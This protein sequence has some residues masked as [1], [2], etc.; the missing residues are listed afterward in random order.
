MTCV[1]ASADI[2]HVLGK[3]GRLSTVCYLVCFVLVP[4]L[5]ISRKIIVVS[6]FVLMGQLPRLLNTYGGVRYHTPVFLEDRE[7]SLHKFG[8]KGKD[9]HA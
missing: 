3:P 6:S 8:G 9:S 5:L 1:A 7:E 4:P 2:R